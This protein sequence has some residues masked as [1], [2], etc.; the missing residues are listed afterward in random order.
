MTY[1]KGDNLVDDQLGVKDWC[2]CLMWVGGWK[3]VGM[4]KPREGEEHNQAALP[5]LACTPQE[6]RTLRT[7][8]RRSALR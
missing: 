8:G 5:P 3:G 6:R 4:S 1:L 7:H 2:I